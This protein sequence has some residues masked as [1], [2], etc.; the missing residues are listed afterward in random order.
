MSYWKKKSIWKFLPLRI[1]AEDPK[2]M[3]KYSL[4]EWPGTNEGCNCSFRYNNY[5]AGSCSKENINNKCNNVEGQDS[6]KIYIIIFL[7]ILLLIMM[8]II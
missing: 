6:K 5:F 3:E 7:N 1:D 4:A 2:D 8:Q